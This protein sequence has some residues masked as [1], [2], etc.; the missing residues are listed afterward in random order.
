ME[1][2]ISSTDWPALAWSE[3]HETAIT[4]QLWTQVVGKIRLALA[5]R[6]NHWWHVPL[7]VTCRGLTTSPMPYGKRMVQIDFDFLDHQLLF[8]THDGMHRTLALMPMTVS[9]FYHAV[10]EQLS[11]LGFE[12][13][14]WTMPVEMADPIA[15]EKDD[16]HAAYDGQAATRFWQVL[17][18]ADRVLSLFRTRF[19]GKVSPIHFFWGSFDLAVTRFS[20]RVAPEHPGGIPHLADSVTRTAYSHEVSS[21]G[22]W[23]G[24]P[25]YEEPVFYAYA[26]PTPPGF[27]EATIRPDMAFF[28]PQMGEYLLPYERVCQL[29]DPD[30]AI[31]EFLQTT[32]EAAANLAHWQRDLLEAHT[33]FI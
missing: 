12:I 8:Q 23:P 7:Y 15:F 17:V 21:C 4:L 3:W 31:L 10:M 32:Y 25:S 6:V 22:F 26:Y 16:T 33:P 27:S 24:G 14:I 11:L 1:K 29:L 18:Q 20:G 13:S 5:P 2:I 9:Q 28:N 30:A 19:I